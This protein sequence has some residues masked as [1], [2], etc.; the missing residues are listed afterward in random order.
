MEEFR[1]CYKGYTLVIYIDNKN[2]NTPT[3]ILNYNGEN[4]D[5]DDI[6]KAKRFIDKG[7]GE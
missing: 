6:S 3:K 2:I 1:A 5:F 7:E 4:L